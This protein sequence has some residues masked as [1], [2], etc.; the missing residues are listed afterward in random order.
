[1]VTA[2]IAGRTAGDA[3]LSYVDLGPSRRH[4][5]YHYNSDSVLQSWGSGARIPVPEG[6][7]DDPEMLLVTT[8]ADTILTMTGSPGGDDRWLQ[9]CP[10]IGALDDDVALYESRSSAPRIIAWTIGTHRFQTVSTI[11]GFTSGEQSYVSSYP[12]L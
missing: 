9:C 2:D 8:D 6:T 10:A 12:E 1:V 5:R 3:S 7:P 11:T 4:G